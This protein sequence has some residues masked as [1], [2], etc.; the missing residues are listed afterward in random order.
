MEYSGYAF[1]TIYETAEFVARKV[2]ETVVTKRERQLVAV[3]RKYA[4]RMFESIS[5]DF[6]PP[7]AVDILDD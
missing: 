3:K 2:S 6:E 7:D 5:R 1:A 4:G